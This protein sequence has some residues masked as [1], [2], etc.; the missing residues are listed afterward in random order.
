MGRGLSLKEQMEKRVMVR[1]K[2]RVRKSAMVSEQAVGMGVERVRLTVE[3][4]LVEERLQREEMQCAAPGG[5]GGSGGGSARD[6]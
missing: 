4:A 3:G 5:G 6:R 1:V 2:V